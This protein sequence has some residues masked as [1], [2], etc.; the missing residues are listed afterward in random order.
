MENAAKRAAG[1]A[2]SLIFDYLDVF[3]GKK[4]SLLS[5]CGDSKA[6]IELVNGEPVECV[7]S[8]DGCAALANYV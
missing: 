8:G 4:G 3:S 2:A 5:A 1:E 6:F 7:G